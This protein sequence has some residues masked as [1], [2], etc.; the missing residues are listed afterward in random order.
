MVSGAGHG[1]RSVAILVRM[2]I[3]VKIELIHYSNLSS[4]HLNCQDNILLFLQQFEEFS[5]YCVTN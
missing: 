2:T 3:S 4:R 1:V 5:V